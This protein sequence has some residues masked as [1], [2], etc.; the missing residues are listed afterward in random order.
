MESEMFR[1]E[2]KFCKDFYEQG[3][4][5]IFHYGNFYISGSHELSFKHGVD[6]C[7]KR[8]WTVR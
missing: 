6:P 5:C 1:R 3:K 8:W 7:E 4:I 2:L